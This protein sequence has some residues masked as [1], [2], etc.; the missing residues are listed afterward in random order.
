MRRQVFRSAICAAVTVMMLTA[1]GA[2]SVPQAAPRHGSTTR[3]APPPFSVMTL[4]ITSRLAPADLGVRLTLPVSSVQAGSVICAK[5]SLVNST[6]HAISLP[7]ELAFGVG[8][9][10]RVASQMIGFA[11]VGCDG[12]RKLLPGVMTYLTPVVTTYTECA[13]PG[14]SFARKIAG[15]LVEPPP[16]CIVGPGLHPAMTPP[17]LPPGTYATVIAIDGQGNQQIRLPRSSVL[18]LTP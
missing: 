9:R 15:R 13:G 12:Y 17:P 7:C 18:T 3:C 11:G 16:K 10:S 5:I 1:C 2:G 4:P 6:D 8:L 14:G